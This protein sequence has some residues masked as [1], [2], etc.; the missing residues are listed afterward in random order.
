[1]S[2]SGFIA[3]SQTAISVTLSRP[4]PLTA[5]TRC[6][7]DAPGIP[8]LRAAV[9]VDLPPPHSIR[10]IATLFFTDEEM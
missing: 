2:L 1:M 9:D 3:A 6:N 10:A 7:R 5:K 8:P 4:G